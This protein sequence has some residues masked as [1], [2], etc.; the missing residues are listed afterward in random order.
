MKLTTHLH[1]VLRS[2]NERS[3]TFNPLIRLHGVVLSLKNAGTNL[4]L[5]YF[6]LLRMIINSETMNP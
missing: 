5:V 4:T 1:L 2:K 3:Y 6:A